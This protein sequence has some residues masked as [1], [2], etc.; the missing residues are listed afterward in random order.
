MSDDQFASFAKLFCE[1]NPA[2]TPDIVVPLLALASENDDRHP[3]GLLPQ[4]LAAMVFSIHGIDPRKKD[5]RKK[6]EVKPV[7]VTP[8]QEVEKKA[9]PVVE[10]KKSDVDESA[11][12]PNY[13]KHCRESQMVPTVPY[14]SC[15]P[16]LTYGYLKYIYNSVRDVYESP[17]SRESDIQREHLQYVHQILLKSMSVSHASQYL[18]A[19]IANNLTLSTGQL[20]GDKLRVTLT[21]VEYATLLNEAVKIVGTYFVQRACRAATELCND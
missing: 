6:T 8:P 11:Q 18:K 19:C 21:R 16:D 15:T 13:V 12:F 5:P 10:I 4:L 20:R 9:E 17:L 7:A 14:D 1:T 2:F 3:K